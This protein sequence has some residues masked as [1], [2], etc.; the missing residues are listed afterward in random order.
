M[1]SLKKQIGESVF[2][3]SLGNIVIQVFAIIGY[4]LIIR[5]LSVHDYGVFVLLV[6][7]IG[8]VAAVAF[9]SLD[10]IFVSK[11]A[12]AKGRGDTSFLKGLFREYYLVGN[13]IIAVLIVA[14]YFFQDAIS[15][16]HDIYLAQYFWYLT[17]FILSQLSMNQVSLFLGANEKFK[18]VAIIETVESVLRTAVVI[19]VVLLGSFSVKGAMLMY[20]SAKL[21]STLVGL[22]Y[23]WPLMRALVLSPAKAQPRVLW[24]LLSSFGKWEAGKNLLEQAVSPVK[25][26][27]IKVFVSVEG[28]AIYDFAR[29]VYAFASKIVPISKVIFPVVSRF[30]EDREKLNLIISKAKK[31]TF[32]AYTMIFV[33][34]LVL[35]PLVLAYI[36]PQYA[37]SELVVYF[38]LLHFLCDTYKVG[39]TAL[40]YAFNKQKFLF[41]VTPLF[42]L[43]QLILD[44]FLTRAFGIFG[45]VLSWHVHAF[46]TGAVFNWYFHSVVRIARTRWSD[47]FCFDAYD[48]IFLESFT[49][50]LKA[51]WR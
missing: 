39:Q 11:F 23:S 6:S 30:S 46:F 44:F 19:G 22:W 45:A 5:E 47:F 24:S 21:A 18:A 49:R 36:F 9:L 7:F 26:T 51:L 13:G 37:G 31:Y 10:Q 1:S 17:A 32:L 28:V 3:N 34:A 38:T 4:F 15:R 20:A 25:F 48:R 12:Q 2:Y 14:G 35:T 40:L 43:S 29:N 42:M 27:L 41:Q 8:P 33:G 50:T 16:A